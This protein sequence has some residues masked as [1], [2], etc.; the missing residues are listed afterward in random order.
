MGESGGMRTLLVLAGLIVGLV[1]F[2]AAFGVDEGE[3]VN[4]TTVDANGARFE[5]Q[6]WVVEEGGHLWLRAGRPAAHWLARL[7]AHPE[8]ELQRGDD[9]AGFR[10]VPVD[11]PATRAAVNRAMAAKYG[12]ADHMIARVFDRENSVPIRLDPLPA[13]NAH[14]TAHTPPESAAR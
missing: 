14:P 6:L 13:A 3:V 7:R 2:M 9:T 11:D 8:V 12:R 5:T 10:A 4:L 1:V